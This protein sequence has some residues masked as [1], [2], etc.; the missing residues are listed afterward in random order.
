MTYIA[1]DA[2]ALAFLLDL[3]ALAGLA[4]WVIP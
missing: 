1:A 3:A 2:I 4:L